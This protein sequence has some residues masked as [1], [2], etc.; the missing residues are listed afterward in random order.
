[1]NDYNAYLRKHFIRR[2][3]EEGFYAY[4]RSIG[5]MAF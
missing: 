3:F 5:H 4:R 2:N 1:M